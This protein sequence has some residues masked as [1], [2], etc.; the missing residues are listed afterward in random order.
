MD[1]RK[2]IMSDACNYII[3]LLADQLLVSMFH[4]DNHNISLVYKLLLM[5]KCSASDMFLLY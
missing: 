4:N 5:F 3:I 2:H 1:A